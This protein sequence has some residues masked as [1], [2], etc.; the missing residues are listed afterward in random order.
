MIKK[1]PTVVSLAMIVLFALIMLFVAS[2][3]ELLSQ[4]TSEKV[5]QQ[6]VTPAV[7]APLAEEG[8]FGLMSM[9]SETSSGLTGKYLTYNYELGAGK[10]ATVIDVTKFD[11]SK[12]Y[13]FAIA[14]NKPGYK[15]Y[16][17]KY[18][19]TQCIDDG[20]RIP[21]NGL[22]HEGGFLKP[23]FQ[24]VRFVVENTSKSAM[25][26]T[27]ALMATADIKAGAYLS[28]SQAIAL[29]GHPDKIK[30]EAYD[31]SVPLKL[32]GTTDYPQLTL[33]PKAAPKLLPF[34]DFARAAGI[35]P[36]NSTA[37]A[38]NKRKIANSQ[39]W[40]NHAFGMA[41]DLLSHNTQGKLLSD[42]ETGKLVSQALVDMASKMG[43]ASGSRWGGSSR[44]S[45][46]WELVQ[47]KF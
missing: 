28:E 37:G 40:S 43:I 2:C 33:H 7:E 19:S 35:L 15:I 41:V 11:S 20:V 12:H 9:V 47:P 29:Y 21:A 42:N 1:K 22:F 26:I 45:M 23:G 6:A 34:I 17:G 16:V 31:L 39:V 27:A 30:A 32:Y 3:T 38:Y 36:N 13:Y 8:K 4:P 25:K 14:S 10:K 46:H 44:D 18:S 24:G 5:Q